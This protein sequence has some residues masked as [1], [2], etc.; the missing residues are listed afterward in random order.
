M[1]DLIFSDKKNLR[2]VVSMLI[3]KG[4]LINGVGMFFEEKSRKRGSGQPFLV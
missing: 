2:T 3:L 4:K 1:T